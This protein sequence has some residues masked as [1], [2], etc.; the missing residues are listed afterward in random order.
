MCLLSFGAG[1]VVVINRRINELT[2]S[3]CGFNT[4]HIPHLGGGI[5][6]PSE[7]QVGTGHPGLY[8]SWASHRMKGKYMNNGD[9]LVFGAQ[10]LR[11]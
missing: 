8:R 9:R 11:L 3:V 2:V 4:A 6:G 10:C 1:G 7:P 5:T